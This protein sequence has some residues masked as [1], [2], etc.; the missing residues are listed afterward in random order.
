M[1]AQSDYSRKALNEAMP[2]CLFNKD[3]DL[4]LKGVST[5]KQWRIRIWLDSSREEYFCSTQDEALE[6]A[7]GFLRD[8]EGSIS[9]ISITSPQRTFEVVIDHGSQGAYCRAVVNG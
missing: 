9:C 1:E 2:V 7:R 5:L 6:V 4:A 3:A 8:Y